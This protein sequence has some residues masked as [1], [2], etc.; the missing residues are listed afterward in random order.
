MR[1]ATGKG[2]AGKAGTEEEVMNDVY[3]VTIIFGLRVVKS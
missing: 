2:G 1:R 3:T